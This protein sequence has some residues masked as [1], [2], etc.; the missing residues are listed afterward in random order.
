M[1]NRRF[2]ADL[3]LLNMCVNLP[4]RFICDVLFLYNSFD[5]F[6]KIGCK[7]YFSKTLY[8]KFCSILSK[9]FSLSTK[10][11]SIF[12]DFVQHTLKLFS[13]LICYL[14]TSIMSRSLGPLQS[15]LS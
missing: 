11:V 14:L 5:H 4:L 15:N 9:A 6:M 10:Y 12:L 7:L 8:T 13:S 1:D 3:S 2:R